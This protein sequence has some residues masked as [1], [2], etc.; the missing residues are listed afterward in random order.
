MSKS[1]VNGNAATAVSSGVI[2]KSLTATGGSFTGV[3]VT[4][5]VEQFV[6]APSVMQY[7]ITFVPKKFV[8]GV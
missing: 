4:V 2:T 7:V 5:M 8:E 6:A 1:F 3:T